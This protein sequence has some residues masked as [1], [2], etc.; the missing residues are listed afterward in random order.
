M[1]E[2]PSFE[3]H[4]EIEL[5]TK[6]SMNRKRAIYP[7]PLKQGGIQVTQWHVVAAGVARIDMSAMRE[8]ATGNQNRKIAVGMSATVSHAAAK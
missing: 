3:R 2:N 1:P 7:E 4:V 8:S 5:P 6:A